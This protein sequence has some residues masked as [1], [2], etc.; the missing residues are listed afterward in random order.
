MPLAWMTREYGNQIENSI[1]EVEEVDVQ[2]DKVGWG[3]CLRVKIS[4]DLQ[5]WLARG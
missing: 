3:N 2:D 1:G 4:L 5:K